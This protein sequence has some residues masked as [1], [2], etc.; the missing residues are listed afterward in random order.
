MDDEP[1][2]LAMMKAFFER[3]GHRVSDACNGREGLHLLKQHAPDVVITDILM[4]EMDG[5]EFLLEKHKPAHKDVSTVPVIAISGGMHGQ[6]IDFLA[7]AKTFGAT[8]VFSKP[9]SLHALHEAV[10]ELLADG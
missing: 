9:V 7:Q 1:A 8:H 2:I 4:P 3:C 6:N 5:L 10:Q